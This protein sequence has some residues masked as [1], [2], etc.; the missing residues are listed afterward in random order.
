MLPVI[1]VT[2]GSLSLDEVR[3]QTLSFCPG[4]VLALERH[5][6]CPTLPEKA[7]HIIELLFL[8]IDK[9]YKI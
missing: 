1:L 9:K 7:I 6:K 3:V 2:K 8:F 5:L 4:K